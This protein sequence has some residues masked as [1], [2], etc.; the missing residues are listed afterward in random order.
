MAQFEI[1]QL[2]RDDESVRQHVERY[3]A[4]RLLSLKT[5]PEAL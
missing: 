3:K 1:I 4:F 2:A 5:A